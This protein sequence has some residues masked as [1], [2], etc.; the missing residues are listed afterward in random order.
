[1][2][3]LAADPP[4]MLWEIWNGPVAIRG[5]GTPAF[6]AITADDDTTGGM[7]AT[8]VVTLTLPARLPDIG[9]GATPGDQDSP[10]PLVDEKQAQDVVGWLRVGRPRG[11]ASND[12]IHR[13]RWVG[14]NAVSAVQARTAAPELL[15]IGTGD[16]DQHFALAQVP[17]LPATVRVQV[18]E[19]DGWQDWVEVETFAR[20]DRD[21]RHVTVDHTTG[22]VSFAAG[23]GRGRVPQIGERIR[24]KTY[25]YGGGLAGN[26]GAG[27]VTAFNGAGAVKVTNPLPAVGG[28]D[29]VSLAEALDAVPAEVH[30]R[31][32]AVT[33]DD[34]RDLAL[35]VT[36]VARAE[37]LPLLH[38]DTPLVAAAGVVS[39]AVFPREDTRAPNAPVPD[40]GLLSRVAA[41][42]D[43]RR[44]VTTELYVIPPTYR[45]VLVSAG[46][47]VRTGYQIDAVRRWV[48]QIVRQYLGPLPPDGPDGTGWPLGRAVRGAEL[49]AVAVQVEGVEFLH[50]LRL[51]VPGPGG[52]REVNLVP[53]ERWE[54]PAL[55]GIT[56]VAGQPLPPGVA[57]APAP[58]E[59][60]LVPLPPDVC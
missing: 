52:P 56:V 27:T 45:E 8:G 34:F 54:V 29:A 24:V 2:T 20:S 51:A 23:A 7:V 28:A 31:D 47:Q 16:A 60:V 58:P 41:H 17:V 44:L 5:S 36:G 32:R 18:E 35:Q 14:L 3:G 55:T 12:P 10:P 4:A 40:R 15:G 42:L 6:T 13:V 59:S 50:G 1:S 19:P 43:Q 48:E 26:V 30:R 25:R 53:L 49:E 9:T 46:V 33:A 21:D 11:T 39:V 57:Y 38:P 22:L 37:T